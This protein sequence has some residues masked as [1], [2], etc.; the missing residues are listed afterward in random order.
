MRPHRSATSGKPPAALVPDRIPGNA[1]PS[2][3]ADELHHM[4]GELQTKIS[5]FRV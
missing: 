2:A 4:V 3:G 5:K 1:L